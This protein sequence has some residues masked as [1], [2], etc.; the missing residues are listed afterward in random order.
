MFGFCKSQGIEINGEE[1]FSD[2]V[3]LNDILSILNINLKNTL[4]QKLNEFFIR[5]GVVNF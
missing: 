1:L 4:C 2:V 3:V 5:K